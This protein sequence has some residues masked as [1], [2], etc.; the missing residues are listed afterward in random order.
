MYAKV[1]LHENTDDTFKKKGSL[2]PCEGNVGTERKAGD[3]GD[4]A[5]K[6]GKK[7]GKKNRRQ[8]L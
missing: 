2:V 4:G 1:N 3:D 5:G 6:K 8:P 7:T